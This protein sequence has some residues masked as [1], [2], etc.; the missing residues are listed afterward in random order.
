MNTALILGLFLL[1]QFFIFQIVSELKPEKNK[2]T[3][4]E[5]I[6]IVDSVHNRNITMVIQIEYILVKRA[7]PSDYKGQIL[8]IVDKSY[9]EISD[10]IKEELLEYVSEDYL[11]KYL[12][13]NANI[14]FLQM[15]QNNAGRQTIN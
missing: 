14:S 6:K 9:N 12:T 3:F 4:E 2:R 10:T 13:Q 5:L 15:I 8:S 11:L 1:S 7:L